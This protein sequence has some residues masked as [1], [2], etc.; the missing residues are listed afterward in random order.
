[1]PGRNYILLAHCMNRAHDYAEYYHSVIMLNIIILNVTP[2]VTNEYLIF[3]RNQV[4]FVPGSQ[5]VSLH[6]SG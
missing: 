2:I 3:Y 6:T 4:R 5:F 1:M